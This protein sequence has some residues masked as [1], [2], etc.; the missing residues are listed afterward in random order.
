MGR[1]VGGAGGIIARTSTLPMLTRIVG[2]GGVL[3]DGVVEGLGDLG[4]DW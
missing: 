1:G 4:I 2:V 3:L